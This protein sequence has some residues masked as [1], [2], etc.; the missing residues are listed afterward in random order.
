MEENEMN[1]TYLVKTWG[2]SAENDTGYF[3]MSAETF[4]RLLNLGLDTSELSVLFALTQTRHVNKGELETF[5]STK[6]MSDITGLS[7]EESRATI[8]R[9]VT[10]GLITTRKDGRLT[11]YNV[12][13]LL[14][15]LK[16][17]LVPN[18]PKQVPLDSAIA[19]SIDALGW[20]D[21]QPQAD[22]QGPTEPCLCCDNSCQVSDLGGAI[23]RDLV[24]G[25]ATLCT[26]HS[27]ALDK[28][29]GKAPT[30]IAF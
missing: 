9:L 25:K 12:S 6:T 15:S 30:R 1:N 24:S 18:A 13:P 29:V 26:T 19:A 3:N 4:T 22:P 11:K 27:V 5:P 21:P 8:D 7:I 16:T 23:L 20:N 28:R 2:T 17:G 14:D 10:K